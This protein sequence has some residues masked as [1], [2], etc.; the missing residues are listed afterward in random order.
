MKTSDILSRARDLVDAGWCKGRSHD[1]W[2][3]HCAV[4]AIALAEAEATCC[5]PGI[6]DTLTVYPYIALLDVVKGFGDYS[7]VPEF[8]DDPG[9]AKQD[10]LNAF[11]KAIISLEEKGL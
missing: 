9:V 4:G 3:N 1:E 5:N 7:G 2:G 8:N 11:D 6:M 10:V